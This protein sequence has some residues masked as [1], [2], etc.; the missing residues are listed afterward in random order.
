MIICVIIVDKNITIVLAINFSVIIVV[1]T[2]V[3]LIDYQNTI[4]VTRKSIS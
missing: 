1:N 2:S 3:L 4:N